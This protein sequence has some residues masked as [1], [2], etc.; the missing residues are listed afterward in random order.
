MEESKGESTEMKK[1]LSFLVVCLAVTMMVPG[2]ALAKADYV[3]KFGHLANTDHTWHKAAVRFAEIVKE[4]SDGRVEV[5]VYPNEQLGK[6]LEMINGIQTGVV[7]MTITGES[8]QNWAPKCGLIA[9]PY[10][11]RSSEHMAAV[12][13][14]PIG[15]EIENEI[16][17]KV[18]L[19]P[20]GWFE[21][22]PRNL[23]SNRPI[24]SPEDLNGFVMRVPNVP[25]FVKVWDALGAK[26]TPMAFSEV[27]TSLQQG[28]IEGQ[29]NPFAL[30]YSASFYEVQKYV[31][32]T[33]HVRGWIYVVIGEKKFQSM[34][35]DL[36]NIILQAGAEMQRYEHE[37]FLANQ[38]KLAEELQ[39]KGMT[40]QEVDKEAFM[41]K[42][43]PAVLEA[44]SPEQAEMY[45]RIVAIK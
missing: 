38:T 45:K 18:G 3:L 11:I 26:P 28:V 25:I 20:V 43:A 36:Q 1:F 17:E 4:K 12:A 14:G 7:D 2:V 32:L 13:G 6:E 5:K 24:K 9:V 33:E 42:A 31:N 41:K 29:E 39:A 21:R 8:L 23:T 30:I 37:L 22:G 19:H 40:L 10:M 16:I 15:K 35:E 34:P 27:F 44:L